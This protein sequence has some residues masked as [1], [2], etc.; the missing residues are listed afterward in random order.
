MELRDRIGLELVEHYGGRPIIVV[1]E[2]HEILPWGAPGFS[3]LARY[4]GR[5]FRVVEQR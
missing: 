4:R 1:P 3:D 2:G 5:T